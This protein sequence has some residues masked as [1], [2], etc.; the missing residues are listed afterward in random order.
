MPGPIQRSV[1]AQATRVLRTGRRFRRFDQIRQRHFW[2]SYLFTPDANGYL[3][4]G[5]FDVFQTPPGQTG[6]GF[7]A[8]LTERE[9]NWRSANRVPDNQNFQITEIGVTVQP[10]T[11]QVDSGATNPGAIPTGLVTNCFLQSTLVAIRYLTNAVELGYCQD[12][13]QASGPTM[14]TYR[15]FEDSAA[16]DTRNFSRFVT[17]G[18]S[19]PGLRRRFKIP[20]LLQHGETFSF[21][22]LIP[23]SFWTNDVS[24]LARLDFWATESFVERS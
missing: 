17:N 9:T 13:A 8:Q 19:A 24:I 2:S 15:P 16:D 10:V 20:I 3:A 14:G 5:D 21:Q 12:F 4:S 22:Y 18:F 23:R 1:R 7:P 11:T 6:Q